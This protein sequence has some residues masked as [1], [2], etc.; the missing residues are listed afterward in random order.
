MDDLPVD[1][2]EGSSDGDGAEEIE[3]PEVAATAT[4]ADDAPAAIDNEALYE[5][6][7]ESLLG[8]N[9]MSDAMLAQK[10]NGTKLTGLAGRVY[11]KLAPL[12]R[13]VAAGSRSSTR[14]PVSLS[15]IDTVRTPAQLGV[16][17]A[18]VYGLA[19]SCVLIIAT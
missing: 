16:S 18:L 4:M 2:E 15:G 14:F 19:F 8:V 6:Y 1:G 12:L 10:V 3:L 5:A 7:I 11:D 13:P 17:A 9:G